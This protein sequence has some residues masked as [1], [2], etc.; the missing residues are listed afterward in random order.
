MRKEVE[1]R[2]HEIGAN[3]KII[4]HMD[5]EKTLQ[6]AMIRLTSPC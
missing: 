1:N 4:L 2:I 5:F 6:N 3:G